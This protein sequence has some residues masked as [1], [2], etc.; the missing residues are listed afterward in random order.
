MSVFRQ[1]YHV[2]ICLDILYCMDLS[3]FGKRLKE[4]RI[5]NKLTQEQLAQKSSLPRSS[6][7]EWELGKREPGAKAIFK[8]AL[9]FDVSADYLLGKNDVI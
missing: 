3:L 5:Q 7:A 1:D 9:F 6:I 4:L 8:I 2:A